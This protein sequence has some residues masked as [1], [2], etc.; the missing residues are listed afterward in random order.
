M[1]IKQL[2]FQDILKSIAQETCDSICTDLI[3][4]YCTFYIPA[5]SLEVQIYLITDLGPLSKFYRSLNGAFFT[6]KQVNIIIIQV[7]TN[8]LR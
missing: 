7:E 1:V 2:N 8:S 6:R 5:I 3:F 4:L